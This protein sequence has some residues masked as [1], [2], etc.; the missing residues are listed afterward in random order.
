MALTPNPKVEF[1]EKIYAELY[2]I[3]NCAFHGQADWITWVTWLR[4]RKL[5]QGDPVDVPDD[6]WFLHT[7]RETDAN[8]LDT[9]IQY[10]RF[11]DLALEKGTEAEVSLDYWN[12]VDL[13]KME[14]YIEEYEESEEDEEV[15]D[16]E[17]S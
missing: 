9:R 5:I 14:I 1:T 15:E 7:F 2:Y 17:G 8:D 13:S 10:Q 3:I 4:C 11:S 6:R 16:D 12:N